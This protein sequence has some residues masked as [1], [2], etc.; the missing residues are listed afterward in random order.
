MSELARTGVAYA[1]VNHGRWIA[2]CPTPYCYNAL[3]I[4]HGDAELCCRECWQVFPIEWPADP[5]SITR[6][7]AARPNPATRNWLPGETPVDLLNESVAHGIAPAEWQDITDRTLMLRIADELV[8]GGVAIDGAI[9]APVY[10]ML[11][12]P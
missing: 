12:G 10:R 7:L 4:A 5:I 3:Q 1:E 2:R 6:L 9:T 8:V 11:E